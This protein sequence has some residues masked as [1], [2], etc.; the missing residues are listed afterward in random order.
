M[1]V[2]SF[3]PAGTDTDRAAR[4]AKQDL[5]RAC[6]MYSELWKNAQDSGHVLDVHRANGNRRILEAELDNM[7]SLM[8]MFPEGQLDR[9][10]EVADEAEHLLDE[11]PVFPPPTTRVSPPMVQMRGQVRSDVGSTGRAPAEDETGAKSVM[12]LID[13]VTENP[14]GGGLEV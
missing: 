14:G 2:N 3:G 13:L 12:D 11:C 4:Q 6:Q 10:R 8:P 1:P 5:R 9:C 7:L